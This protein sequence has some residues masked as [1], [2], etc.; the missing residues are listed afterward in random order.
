MMN[1]FVLPR[2]GAADLLEERT[3]PCPELKPRD[4]LVRVHAVA[5]NPVDTQVRDARGKFKPADGPADEYP[6]GKILG[7]DGSGVVEKLGSEVTMFQEGDAVYFA[8][9]IH[10]NGSN[11]DFVAIDE[12]IVAKMPKSLSFAE[13]AAVP[14]TMLT[15]WEG[16]FES[17]RV[18]TNG[19]PNVPK[20]VLVL[21]GAGGVGTWAIQLAKKVGGLFVIA[22]ASRPESAKKSMELGADLVINHREPLQPQLEAAGLDGVDYIYDG[23]G[24]ATYAPQYAEIIKPFGQIVTI[25][26]D[27][28]KGMPNISVPMTF[29]RCSIHFE[30]MF[31]RAA[32]GIEMERQHEILATAARLIDEGE[33]H[34]SIQDKLP[35]SLDSLKKAHHMQQS[36]QAIGK[37]VMARD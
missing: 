32:E 23:Y 25:V 14:L 13:A 4:I 16:L 12:R 20:R 29:K 27:F 9:D 33:L 11:A 31:T 1:A 10:R 18:P 34:V 35:W 15:A 26:P 30:L 28:T 2:E 36:G 37:I 21:P 17:M 19:R 24:L 8:G 22:T 7:Y 5:M 3:L 6:Q